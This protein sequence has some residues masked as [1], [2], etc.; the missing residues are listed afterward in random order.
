MDRIFI[1]GLEVDAVIGVYDW[2]QKIRQTLVLD[3]ELAWD[4][5]TAASQDALVHTIDYDA[6]SQRLTA[7]I[8]GKSFQLLE[9]V[10][11]DCAE[12]LQQEF[13]VPGLRLR[14][15]KPGAVKNARAVGVMIERGRFSGV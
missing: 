13:H 6:V 1:E 4:T 5:R 11:Q 7:H 3:L 15:A 8:R 12:I 14:I 10:A 9:T 2:E